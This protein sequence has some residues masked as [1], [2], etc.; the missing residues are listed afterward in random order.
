MSLSTQRGL[1]GPSNHRW[2]CNGK[3]TKKNSRRF[4]LPCFNT[5]R[6]SVSVNSNNGMS[7]LPS[8]WSDHASAGSDSQLSGSSKI[9]RT[10]S[11]P[12]RQSTK[13]RLLSPVTVMLLLLTVVSLC[14]LQPISA[15]PTDF[16]GLT[17]R[18]SQDQHPRWNTECLVQQERLQSRSLDSSTTGKMHKR[19]SKGQESVDKQSSKVWNNLP[20]LAVVNSTNMT[21]NGRADICDLRYNQVVSMLLCSLA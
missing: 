17:Q 18:L 7:E 2:P 3:T 20:S 8:V 5:E 16:Q 21:C 13:G 14:V 19:G 10:A 12:C 11:S 1:L 6:V 15:A 4:P 9:S